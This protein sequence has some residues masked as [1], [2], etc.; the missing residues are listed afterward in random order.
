MAT[1]APQTDKR[2]VDIHVCVSV[3]MSVL[4]FVFIMCHVWW[5]RRIN[6]KQELSFSKI[7]VCTMST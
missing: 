2:S 4:S 1:G 3:G 5:V 7:G 6:N